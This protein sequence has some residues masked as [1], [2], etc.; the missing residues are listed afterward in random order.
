M[1]KASRR[2]SAG[3]KISDVAQRAG[4]SPMTVSRVINGEP[5]VR[6]STRDLVRS[7]IK[8]LNYS[9]NLAARSL[10]R[11]DEVRLGVIYSNPSAGFLSEFLVGVL[12]ETQREGAQITL[13]RCEDG[14]AAELEAVRRLVTGGV[15]GVILPPPH[16]ESAA[17]Q[18]A[19][20]R[21][22][23]PVA[24]VAAG[25]PP[26]GAICVRVDD[27]LAAHDMAQY[28]LQLGHRSI[29]VIGGHPNQ[30]SSPERLAG[31]LGAL[32]NVKGA[33]LSLGQGLFDYPSGLR[34]A[35]ILLDQNARPTAIFALNDD[36]A[37]AVISVAHRR[38]LDVPNDLTVVGFDDTPLAMTLWPPLTT[39]RQPVRAMASRAAELLIRQ[40]RST[41]PHL[42]RRTADD[43]V[44][45]YLLIER[46]SAG[47]PRSE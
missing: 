13:V 24:V 16:S 43:E 33:T 29:G 17:L 11:A 39:I 10:A 8:E 4:V 1:A 3:V 22:E 45:P 14:E 19:L 21:E 12:D 32:E 7:A 38:G 2:S 42:S 31:I 20:A 46:Q 9:P 30:T 5:N 6:E 35:E 26:Q 44:L 36:M 27:R 47:P 37:A 23:I 41:P 25:R 40:I 28:L 15:T 18:A 34:A